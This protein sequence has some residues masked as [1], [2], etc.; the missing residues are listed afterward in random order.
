MSSFLNQREYELLTGF[1]SKKKK[2]YLCISRHISITENKTKQNCTSRKCV[3]AYIY[4]IDEP[5]EIMGF[6]S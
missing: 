6:K 3:A 2:I 1:T 4:I 5:M